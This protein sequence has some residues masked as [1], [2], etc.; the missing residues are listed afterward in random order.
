MESLPGRVETVKE[1]L[2]RM[3]H[4]DIRNPDEDGQKMCVIVAVVLFI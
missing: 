1:G 3:G 2:N 4:E